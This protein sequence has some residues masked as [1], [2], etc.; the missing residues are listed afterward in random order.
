[1]GGWVLL[2]SPTERSRVC[3]GLRVG[4]GLRFVW[5][6]GFE[7]M[8]FI[9]ESVARTRTYLSVWYVSRGTLLPKPSTSHLRRPTKILSTVFRSVIKEAFLYRTMREQEMK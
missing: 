8:Y 4:T 9:K 1:M 7:I 5:V 2:I 6:E 3:W